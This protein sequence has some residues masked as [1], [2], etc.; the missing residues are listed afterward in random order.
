M[1]L[2]LPAGLLL[3]AGCATFEQLEPEPEISSA[4]NGYI[5]IRD[6]DEPF[7][8]EKDGKYFIRFPAPQRDNFYL[9]LHTP[10]KSLVTTSLTTRFDEDKGALD[11]ITDEAASNDTLSVYPV[12]NRAPVL[13][14]VIENVAQDMGVQVRPPLAVY[15]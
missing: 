6:D 11:R 4:E 9:I 2:L 13:T 8:L 14:W 10:P 3:A 5:E 1:T 7:E 15:V 12:D